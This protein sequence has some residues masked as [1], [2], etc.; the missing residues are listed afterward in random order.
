MALSFLIY[1]LFFY[2]DNTLLP[3]NFLSLDKPRQAGLSR[4][5]LSNAKTFS[6]PV[7]VVKPK[8]LLVI[9]DSVRVVWRQCQM[10][11][12]YTDTGGKKAILSEPELCKDSL[13][14][15]V[16]NYNF[17][18]IPLYHGMCLFFFTFWIVLCSW[19]NWATE[20]GVW[21]EHPSSA[22]GLHENN[23]LLKSIVLKI[24]VLKIMKHIIED[25]T[26]PS[27]F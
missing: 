7:A 24:I 2:T 22:R 25:Q 5:P 3:R 1:K 10:E 17:A 6:K 11:C 4:A 23:F 18:K 13:S 16:F 26:K 14:G 21:C 8:D 20:C 12:V 27:I 15:F 9:P 19:H